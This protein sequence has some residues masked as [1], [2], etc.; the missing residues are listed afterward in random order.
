VLPMPDQADL[1][2]LARSAR[3]G[4]LV[5]V[6]G[7]DAAAGEARNKI[8]AL[9][10]GV[11]VRAGAWEAPDVRAGEIEEG[12][13]RDVPRGSVVAIEGIEWLSTPRRP[14]RLRVWLEEILRNRAALFLGEGP[15]IEAIR[16]LAPSPSRCWTAA[17]GQID[18]VL[19]DLL[20]KTRGVRPLAPPPVPGVASRPGLV[21]IALMGAL[22]TASW[23][24]VYIYYAGARN[25]RWLHSF[26]VV[27][28]MAAV[29]A[30]L[31]PW[32]RNAAA[33]RELA[34]SECYARALARWS[35]WPRTPIAVAI[36]LAA[37][38]GA[39][40][41]AGRYVPATFLVIYEAAGVT[42]NGRDAGTCNAEEPCTL[43]VPRGATLNFDGAEGACAMDLHGAA[44]LI[45]IDM[46]EDGCEAPPEDQTQKKTSSGQTGPGE[47]RMLY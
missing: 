35:R 24:A 15:E 41:L 25:W 32:V 42:A 23:L 36:M 14:T 2:R 8:S 44:G 30:A 19:D 16:K 40:W 45:V 4:R 18:A 46:D 28:I 10:C 22:V 31:L 37:A 27:A 39:G 33:G 20:E 5:A 11:W 13:C 3:R 43:V 47:R 6:V 21:A 38:L 9:P 26:P 34:A 29:A 12:V 7:S 17:G 1:E